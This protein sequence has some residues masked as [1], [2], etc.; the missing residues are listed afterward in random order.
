MAQPT[1]MP[2]LVSD[3]QGKMP[4]RRQR[5]LPVAASSATVAPSVD[6]FQLCADRVAT[7]TLPP[8]ATGVMAHIPSSLPSPVRQTGLPDLASK[9]V[10]AGASPPSLQ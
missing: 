8:A 5:I 4:C 10:T 1:T 6:F 2:S 7:N 9:A 3:V